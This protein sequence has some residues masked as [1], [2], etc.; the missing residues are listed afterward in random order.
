MRH[1]HEMERV[2]VEHKE[3]TCKSGA[4]AAEA[5]LEQARRK[6]MERIQAEGVEAVA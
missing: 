1:E 2:N 3:L 5:A 4:S 6:A